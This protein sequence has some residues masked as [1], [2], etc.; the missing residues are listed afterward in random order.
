MI[1]PAEILE[2]AKRLYPQAIDAWLEGDDSHRYPWRIPANRK[3]ADQHSQ[4][5]ND[6]QELRLGAKE[7]VGYGYSLEWEFRKSRR[8]GENNFVAGV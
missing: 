2:K 5:I 3:L 4:N 7:S 8:H 6:V 1:N